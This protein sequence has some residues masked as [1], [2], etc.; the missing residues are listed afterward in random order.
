M[1]HFTKVVEPYKNTRNDQTRIYVIKS[2]NQKELENQRVYEISRKNCDTNYVL[3]EHLKNTSYTTAFD[4][5]KMLTTKITRQ[6]N[7]QKSQLDF[8]MESV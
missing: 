1:E 2:E 8:C 7:G 5:I 3:K 6:K 4:K